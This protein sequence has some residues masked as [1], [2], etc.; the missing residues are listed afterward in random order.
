MPAKPFPLIADAHLD[1][2]WNAIDWNRDLQL[3]VA[4]IRRRAIENK[5][6]GKGRGVGTVAFPD[7]R[8]GR[9]GLGIILDVTHLSDQCFYEALD[10]YQGP[11]LA[12]HHNCRALVPDQRQLADEHVK[13]L[14]QRGAVIGAAMDDWMLVPNWVRGETTPQK[15]GVCLN[16]V[17]DHIDRACQLAGNARHAALGTDLDG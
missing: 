2:A 8:R 3:P 14:V 15:T 11:V 13:L 12:S 1:L 10:I 16:T 6:N 5:L 9:D 17:V 7:P 4:E